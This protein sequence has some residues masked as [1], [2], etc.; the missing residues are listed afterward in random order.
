[1]LTVNKILFPMPVNNVQ[2]NRNQSFP[3]LQPLKNDT[4][5]FSGWWFKTPQ[6]NDVSDAVMEAVK[7]AEAEN[8]RI[9]FFETL[10]LLVEDFS[11]DLAG[12]ADADAQMLYGDN[13]VKAHNLLDLIISDPDPNTKKFL[14][15]EATRLKKRIGLD[16]VR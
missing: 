3:K 7:K 14:K 4:V 12:K 15:N 6:V 8:P 13:A 16:P 9:N 5:S 10:R 2:N 1:M 11:D